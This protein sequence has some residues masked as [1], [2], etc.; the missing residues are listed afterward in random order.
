MDRAE[1]LLTAI[2]QTMTDVLQSQL[3]PRL[4]DLVRDE[5]DEARQD[6]ISEAME[7]GR[8]D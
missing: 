4:L 5:L 1:R 3:R 6:G 7:V 8:G 2:F